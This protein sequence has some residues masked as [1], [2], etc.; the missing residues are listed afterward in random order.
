MKNKL[1]IYSFFFSFFFAFSSSA[2][3]SFSI[4][5]SS[6]SNQTMKSPIR[7]TNGGTVP[8][9]TNQRDPS[10]PVP[11][12]A[13]IPCFI[14]SFTYNAKGSTNNTKPIKT[15]TNGFM[16]FVSPTIFYCFKLSFLMYLNFKIRFLFSIKFV[17]DFFKIYYS[18]VFYLYAFFS[19]YFY[20][21]VAA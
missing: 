18:A 7:A 4:L 9:I 17:Q 15:L 20:F 16:C 19:Q 1:I 5:H 21:F 2:F 10:N 14:N 11:L 8:L 13:F 6:N 3:S 12:N